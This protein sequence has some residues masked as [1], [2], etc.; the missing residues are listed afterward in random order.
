MADE[1]SHSSGKDTGVKG[2]SIWHV[3]WTRIS[4]LRIHRTGLWQ[5][6]SRFAGWFEEEAATAADDR[7]ETDVF[8]D[9]GSDTAGAR[10]RIGA[11]RYD[12]DLGQYE[13]LWSFLRS[14]NV[15][16]V[17][18]DPRIERN[19]IEDVLGV[20]YAGRKAIRKQDPGSALANQ[21]MSSEGLHVACTRTSLRDQT[22]TVLYS[23]CTL[24]FSRAVRWFEERHKRFHD[25]RTLFYAAPRYGAL[26]T[27]AFTGP[28]LLIAILHDEWMLAAVLTLSGLILFALMYSLFMVVGSVEYDNEE[29]AYNLGRA[30]GR[31]RG[32]TEMIQADIQR[33]RAVQEAFIPSS[34]GMPFHDRIEWAESFVP[35]SEVGGDY[36]DVA[37]LDAQRVAILFSDVSGHGMGAA[38]ITAIMKTTFQ[39]WLDNK[40]TL[41]QLGQQ[42]NANLS[43]LVPLGSFA[44]AFLA[45]YDVER[46]ELV[47]ANC[48]HQPEPWHVSVRA[49]EPVQ[50][51]SDAGNMVMGVVESMQIVASKRVLGPG[52]VVLFVSDGIVENPDAD[53]GIYGIERF[54]E[55]VEARRDLPPSQLVQ[56]IRD[57]AGERSQESEQS[58][59]QTVLAFRVKG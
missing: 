4:I 53:G 50:V 23:Y 44:A 27:V 26:I 2:P 47:Y 57:E 56:A 35:A 14:L 25:H 21:L 22:L 54:E 59:D 24:G 58:D 48:G 41:E 30:Y 36:F 19:Q 18:L 51:L 29:K 1:R 6:V 37:R 3:I 40:G 20:L 42:M 55:F 16:N 45:I 34:D 28:P 15:E 49:K 11:R 9:L 31:L 10:L 32:Y 39:A 52:D 12:H 17:R 5:D 7:S 46:R 8:V 38:F 13:R 33:A 43:R